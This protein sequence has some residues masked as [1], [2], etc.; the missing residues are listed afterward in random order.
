MVIVPC[1]HAHAIP[2]GLPAVT[3]I[4][5]HGSPAI[6]RLRH[7]AATSL[8]AVPTASSGLLPNRVADSSASPSRSSSGKDG[9][10][11]V[12]LFLVRPGRPIDP[13]RCKACR[14]CPEDRHQPRTHIVGHG[15]WDVHMATQCPG[16]VAEIRHMAALRE[17]RGRGCPPVVT[18]ADG[19]PCN[20]AA[21]CVPLRVPTSLPFEANHLQAAEW[22]ASEHGAEAIGT[23][24][25]RAIGER[26]IPT[27]CGARTRIEEED[28]SHPPA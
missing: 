21:R 28:G 1:G 14:A 17:L 15:R 7:L 6:L 18:V 11:S 22:R 23:C 24:A 26:R 3:T 19:N 5:S 16:R 27:E 13:R 4:A 10:Q 25:R 12:G 9:H 20:A 2:T 8:F